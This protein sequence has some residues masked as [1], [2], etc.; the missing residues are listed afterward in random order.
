VPP[1]LARELAVA[2]DGRKADDLALTMPGGSH[3]RLS[4]WRQAAFMPARARAGISERF[5][6]M[7]CGTPPR[8]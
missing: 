5:G 2:L 8:H 7:T 4:N 3:L 6:F 1:F